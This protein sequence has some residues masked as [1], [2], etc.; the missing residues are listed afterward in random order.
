VKIRYTAFKLDEMPPASAKRA[1]FVGQVRQDVATALEISTEQVTILSLANGSVITEIRFTRAAPTAHNTMTPEQLQ[2][3]LKAQV[4]D[5]S[6]TSRFYT[7]GVLSDSVDAEFFEECACTRAGLS[8]FAGQAGASLSSNVAGSI[9][10]IVHKLTGALADAAEPVPTAVVT[11]IKGPPGRQGPVGPQ[12]PRGEKGDEGPIGPKGDTGAP[13]AP[14]V[15]A[16]YQSKVNELEARVNSLATQDATIT[17]MESQLY[18]VWGVAAN[19]C[20]DN[21]VRTKFSLHENRVHCMPPSNPLLGPGNAACNFPAKFTEH[22]DRCGWTKHCRAPWAGHGCWSPPPPA[23]DS[24][25]R[26]ASKS[27]SMPLLTAETVDA[28]AVE[29]ASLPF[30]APRFVAAPEAPPAFTAPSL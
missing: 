16:S 24:L 20:P 19:A 23:A 17:E 14:A 1:W 9:N 29:P 11:I 4:K 2:A 26:F 8:V 28:D 18:P 12:G 15:V 10:S 25:P 22:Y 27:E 30:E 6:K 13:V 3:A 7:N 5:K 21:W